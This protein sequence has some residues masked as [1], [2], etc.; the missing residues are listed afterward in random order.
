M[1]D[2]LNWNIQSVSSDGHPTR[3]VAKNT[4]KATLDDESKFAGLEALVREELEK[5]L[6]PNF[7]RMRIFEDGCLEIVTYV[8]AK[9]GFTVHDSKLSES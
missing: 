5:H 8:E 1:G 7:S 4:G 2:A 3:R 9:F 6:M